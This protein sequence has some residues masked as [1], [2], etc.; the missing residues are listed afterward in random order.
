MLMRFNT[1]VS[2]IFGGRKHIA[3]KEQNAK[4]NDNSHHH[5]ESVR[6]ESNSGI[7]T[8]DISFYQIC[9]YDHRSII[10]PRSIDV[11]SSHRHRHMT[12]PQMILLV[13]DKLCICTNTHE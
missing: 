13:I 11:L 5:L 6:L 1:I 7:S 2:H 8:G 3:K 10:L 4:A 12:W 9:C